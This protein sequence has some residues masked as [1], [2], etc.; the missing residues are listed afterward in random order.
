MKLTLALR[1]LGLGL[2]A[3]TSA[4]SSPAMPSPAESLRAIDRHADLPSAWR[5]TSAQKTKLDPRPWSPGETE[6]ARRAALAG[7]EEMATWFESNPEVVAE[8][9]TN[10]VECFLNA[11]YAAGDHRALRR[12]SLTEARRRLGPL[13]TPWLAREPADMTPDDYSAT[14]TLAVYA[15]QIEGESHPA[16]THLRRL[17]NASAAACQDL[18]DALGYSWRDILSSQPVAN[19]DAYGLLLWLVTLTD[20][21]TVPGLASPPGTAEFGPR[22]WAMLRDYPFAVARDYPESANNAVFYDDAYLATHIGYVPTG[23]GRHRLRV[24]DSPNL[25]RYLRENFYAVLAMGELDLVAE[26]VDL[27]RQYGLDAG[28]DVQVRDGTRQLMR[29][30]EAAGAWMKHRESYETPESNPYDLI[31]KP[32]TGIAGVRR[33]RPEV[34]T[35][36]NYRGQFEA[37]CQER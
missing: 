24:A 11:S 8:L 33:R 34:A 15:H 26:F 4:C 23:Y 2:L 3:L 20:A 13:L 9:D 36:A 18:E 27:L 21:R 1:L 29:Q 14:V 19:G 30:Y 12:R 5:P 31:H 22:V 32:W 37:W 16:F 25:Y 35:A 10:A 7:V 6:A 17:A 28:N